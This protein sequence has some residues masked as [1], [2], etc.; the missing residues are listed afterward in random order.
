[1][2]KYAHVFVY[3]SPK[4]F[5]MEFLVK[6]LTQWVK[7]NQATKDKQIASKQIGSKLVLVSLLYTRFWTQHWA[8][9]YIIMPPSH[10]LLLQSLLWGMWILISIV[11]E[12]AIEDGMVSLET[13][14]WEDSKQEDHYM[15]QCLHGIDRQNGRFRDRLSTLFVWQ[16]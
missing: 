5:C 3:I 9:M 8:N 7:P 2:N 4:R 12:S 15:F 11:H 14:L 6:P 10:F 1:M 16:L 13:R